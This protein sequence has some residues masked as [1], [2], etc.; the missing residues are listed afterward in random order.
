MP[1]V[2]GFAKLDAIIV[3]AREH[4]LKL[5]VTLNDLPVFYYRPLYTD[6]ARYDAQTAFIVSRYRNEPTILAWDL[7]N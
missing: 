7:R 3:L 6:Y 5:I 4:N 1:N 2:A